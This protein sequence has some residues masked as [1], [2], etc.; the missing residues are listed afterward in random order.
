MSTMARISYSSSSGS[1][2]QGLNPA[3][4]A[5]YAGLAFGSAG[6]GGGVGVS[7]GLSRLSLGTGSMGMGLGAGGAIGLKGLGLNIGQASGLGAAG[8]GIGIGMGG[9]I[10]GLSLGT[11]VGG[12]LYSSPA[13]TMGRTITAGGLSLGSL[14]SSGTVGL[15]P[16][17]NSAVVKQTLATLNERFSHYMERVKQLQVENKTLEAQL[18]QLTGGTSVAPDS[19]VSVNYEVQLTDLRHTLETLALGNVKLE[20][21]L[22]NIR[23]TAEELNAKYEFELG[24]KYQLETD[25]ASMK[26]DIETA[27]DLH[28]ELVSKYQSLI[29]KLEYTNK[30]QEEELSALQVKLGTTITDTSVSMIEVDTVKSFNLTSALNKMRT[31]YEKSVQQHKDDAELYFRIQMDS[32]QSQASKNTEAMSTV[33]GEMS[34]TRKELQTLQTE[35][36]YL[37]SVNYTLENNLAEVVARSNIGVA[38]FQAQIASLEAAIDSAKIELHKQILAYQ[39]MLDVKQALDVEISTYRKLLEGEDSKIADNLEKYFGTYTFMKEAE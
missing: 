32:I 4:K 26:K 28:T 17:P 29:E 2:G 34:A 35:L 15:V 33:K 23:G 30:T 38:E 7:T 1:L 21:E 24:V 12:A 36:Q 18:N 10:G 8:L 13:F 37:L 25:T 3:L 16:L 19:S 22:D 5:G 14:L 27:T 39:E 6:L 11:G 31:E 20:V 9:G